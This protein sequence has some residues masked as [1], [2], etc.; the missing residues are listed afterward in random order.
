MPIH[1][2]A[3]YWVLETQ[4]TGYALGLNQAGLLAHCYWGVRLPFI[5]DYPPP[6]DPQA[7]ASFDDAAHQTPEEYPGYAG[8]RY[9][10]PCLKMTFADGVRDVVLRFVAAEVADDATPEL[11]IHL[12]DVVYPLRVTLHYRLHE[13]YD[14]IERWV[15][16]ANNGDTPISVE[17]IWSAQ[18]H[19]PPG[20]DYRLS[21]LTGRWADEMHLRREPLVHGCKVLESR[22]LHTSHQHNPWFALDRGD[23]DE[24]NGAVWFGVLAWS[25]NWK[26]AAEVADFAAA[27]VSI[28][29][30]DWDFAWRLNPGEAFSA[31]SSYAGYTTAGFGGASR[32][33]H[34]FIRDRILPHDHSIH[35]VLYNSWEA[36]LFDVDVDAQ[37]ELA[38]LAAAMGVELFVMDDGWFH[39]RND[40]TAGLGDWRPDERK[41]PQGLTPLIERVNALGMEFGLWIEPEMVN[42]NSELYR[43]HPDWV[44]HFPTRDR[45]TARNQIILNIARPDVQAHLIE[46]IDRLLTMHNI[47]FIKWDMNRAVSEP[48]WPEAPGDPRELWV[49]YVQGLY[50]VWGTLR[51]RHPHVTWQSCSGGG[52]RSDLGIL[53]LADQIWVSDNTEPTARLVIQ[54]GFSQVFPANTMEAWVTDL[55]WADLP[56]AFRFHVSMCGALGIGGHLARW[57]AERRAEAAHW[58]ALYKAIRPIIQF[59]DLYRLRSPHTHP[60]SAVQFVSKDRTEGVLFAFRTYLRSPATLPP[61]YLRGLDPAARYEVE[62]IDGVRSGQAWMSVG[63]RLD[64]SDFQSTMR[65]IWLV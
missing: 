39:G 36:T 26:L 25:G 33:L 40:D 14:L 32:R 10:E 37:I 50:Y 51:T 62:G 38:E 46:Q 18:W 1:A 61:L 6:P 63:L 16:I 12:R 56:L 29:I 9:G 24:D 8:M 41:F 48:G 23:A 65:R 44:I 17:R 64:L 54:E 5:E 22:R 2:S 19:L 31:P 47:A 49:R 53:R 4:T 15:V 7:W 42:P 13:D 28:G 57:S 21:H 60:F 59:G 30:N 35:K 27:R 34:D 11:R 52:G 58:I 43:A 3:S 45:T 20:G 55:G